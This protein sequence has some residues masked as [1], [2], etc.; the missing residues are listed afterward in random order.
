MQHPT[1]A[2]RHCLYNFICCLQFKF[3]IAVPRVESIPHIL[4]ILYIYIHGCMYEDAAAA[5]SHT[6]L[7]FV[8]LFHIKFKARVNNLS[9]ELAQ[10]YVLTACYQTKDRPASRRL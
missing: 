6:P 3:F 10:G 8:R 9:K 4:T 5:P 2:P 7:L 1:F